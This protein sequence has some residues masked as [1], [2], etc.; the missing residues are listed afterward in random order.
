[1]LPNSEPTIAVGL[2]SSADEL[3]F[4]LHGSFSRDGQRTEA[5]SY[6]VSL[7]D[8]SNIG[9][10]T[11]IDSESTF[12]LHSVVIGVTFHWRRKENQSFKGSLRI[13]RD[14]GGKLTAINDI[15]LEAYLTSVIASEMS[16][17]A[18]LELLKAHA[19]ISRSWL[20]AQLK[21]WRDVERSAGTLIS[22]GQL[23][24]WYSQENHQE[25]DVCADDHCQ[26]YQGLTKAVGSNVTEAIRSTAGRAL[27]F[28]DRLCDARYSKACGGMTEVYAAAWED[29]V[30]PYLTSNYDGKEFPA[31]FKLPL[32]EEQNADV[33]I[34]GTPPA[35]CFT[36]DR[37]AL[38]QVLPDFDQETKDYYR[39]QVMIG[40]EEL[41]ALLRQ[42]LAEL[43]ELG[44]IRA[45][46]PVER[47]ESGRLMRLRF[48]GL[49][50]SLVVGKE[51]E[52]RRALSTS[53][54]YSSA[55][56]VEPGPLV[57]GV[58]REFTLLGAGW[59]HGVGLCQIGAAM[60]AAQGYG[61]EDILSH[62][63][64]GSILSTLY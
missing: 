56:V 18:G 50:R 23:I 63:Y 49:E 19:V 45:I 13:I 10:Y 39:W 31:Q 53:H 40:Q 55:F 2:I 60:M 61:Y 28:G 14:A 48:V 9:T 8:P 52:I 15:P 22:G 46:E 20:L 44:P 57:G 51:L 42:K 59:G 62:Y 11:P 26:R 64:P 16:S 54:L 6:R 7:H 58:P 37:S 3:T 41:Q 1:M 47:G 12:T 17:R 30:I 33:W 4:D 21:S 35:F 24:R 5:G 25:F 29:R 34:R 27:T 43:G 36:D 32:T 38:E